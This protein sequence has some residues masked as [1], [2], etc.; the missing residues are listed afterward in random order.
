MC[1]RVFMVMKDIDPDDRQDFSSL[2]KVMQTKVID[3]LS[4][5]VPNSEATVMYIKICF[6]LASSL[7]E[8]NI[9]PVDRI[10]R[11][12]YATLF[13]RIWRKW[14]KSFVQ[15]KKSSKKTEY[16]LT[17]SENFLT[18]NAYACIEI[19]AHNLIFWIKTFRNEQFD[20]IFFA[21]FI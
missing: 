8:E 5:H 11:I 1:R 12:W 14:L 4:V 16:T 9:S 6:S 10:Y 2:E 13:L 7:Y 15:R 18:S 21:C 19:N 3:A 20:A 17:I